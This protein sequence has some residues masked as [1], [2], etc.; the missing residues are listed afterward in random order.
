MSKLSH[1][2]KPLMD[3]HWC[4]VLATLLASGLSAQQAFTALKGQADR[5]YRLAKACD[6]TL[7][8][9]QQGA[10]LVS[11]MARYNFFNHYQLE[12][13]KIGELSGSLPLTLINIANR[14]NRQYERN[15]RLKTQL[16]LSQAVIVIG[17][18]AGTIITATKGG[19]FFYEIVGLI[20]VVVVTK[21][22]YMMLEADIF[23]VLAKVWQRQL[24]MR[25]VGVFKRL[26]EYYWYSLLAAQLEAGIDPV[27]ALMNLHDLFPSSLLKR[28]TRIC[29]RYLEK[30]WSMVAAL[31]QSKLIL[32]SSMKQ[33]L[34]TG[35]KSGRLAPTL[36]YHLELEEKHL[37]V[38]TATFYEWLPRFYY[39]MAVGVVLHFMV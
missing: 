39:V 3:A 37:E 25:N 7:V 31:S 1:H 19:S 5:H 16:K 29:Q 27:R 21:L 6:K 8:D 36:K 10:S 2:R 22:I 33:T 4:R 9:I 11:A 23:S 20:V 12:Q 13:L 17:L 35:E 32:T 24:I 30:G 28:N 38:A 18:I 34:W 26:F 14:L 15:Q